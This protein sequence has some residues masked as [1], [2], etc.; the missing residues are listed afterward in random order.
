[1]TVLK[2]ENA[3]S[4]DILENLEYNS[5]KVRGICYKPEIE[6]EI[7]LIATKGLQK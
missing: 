4:T 7:V 2:Y 6:A 1:M 3:L 5:L